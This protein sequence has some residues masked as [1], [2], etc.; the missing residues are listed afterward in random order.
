MLGSDCA[1]VPVFTS[2]PLSTSPRARSG[3]AA[4]AHEIHP[5][6]SWRDFPA[7]WDLDVGCKHALQER[8]HLG[9]LVGDHAE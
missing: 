7:R 2:V 4:A 1:A 6:W 3:S 8:Q 5:I 9:L